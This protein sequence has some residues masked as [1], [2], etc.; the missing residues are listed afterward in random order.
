MTEQ[1]TLQCGERLLTVKLYDDG[2]IGIFDPDGRLLLGW[3]ETT[4]I[5]DA[6]FRDLAPDE[7]CKAIAQ[8]RKIS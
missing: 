3:P 4:F 5:R 8:F 7:Q 2:L 6:R 1:Y